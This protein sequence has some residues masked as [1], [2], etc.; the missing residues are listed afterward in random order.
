MGVE[1]F[2]DRQKDLITRTFFVG[3]LFVGNFWIIDSKKQIHPYLAPDPRGGKC[4]SVPE[5]FWGGL[6]KMSHFWPSGEMTEPTPGVTPTPRVG[7]G[8]LVLGEG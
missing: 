7:S 6:T 5:K 8:C 4:Q 1:D 3:N 2:F